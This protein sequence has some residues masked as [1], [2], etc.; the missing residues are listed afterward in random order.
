M[1]LEKLVKNK[2]LYYAA[3]ALMAINVVGYIA[4]GSIECVVV[5]GV[6]AY[7]SNQ[8]TKNNTL[9]IFVALFVSNVIF[10]CGRVKEGLENQSSTD[11]AKKAAATAKTEERCKGLSGE[12]LKKCQ[13]AKVKSD[14]LA[15]AAVVADKADQKAS[16]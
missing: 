4:M 1:K 2:Y 5:F 3:V 7:L 14:T 8:F 16:E 12:S 13:A 6:A 15:Q 9:D 10:G 11:L